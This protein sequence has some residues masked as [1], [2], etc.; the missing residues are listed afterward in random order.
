MAPTQKPTSSRRLILA[1]AALLLLSI[2][3]PLSYVVALEAGIRRGQRWDQF[4][5][6]PGWIAFTDAPD[7]ERAGTPWF[8]TSAMFLNQAQ[9]NNL[10]HPRIYS[11]PGDHRFYMPIWMI[12]MMCI[13]AVVG[14]AASEIHRRRN[15][16][17]GCC[18]A[19]GYD[20]RATPDRCPEC[21]RTPA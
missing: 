6:G 4:T 5:S 2:I 16:R 13:V 10:Q 11:M 1:V 21:G 20:L 8:G 17:P 15:Y 19:C 12:S 18:A 9:R 3:W 14:L 7:H